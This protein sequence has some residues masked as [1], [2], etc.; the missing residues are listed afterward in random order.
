MRVRI[1]YTE[2]NQASPYPSGVLARESS[3]L[4]FGDPQGDIPIGAPISQGLYNWT[5]IGLEGE[6]PII[7]LIQ[8]LDSGF[9]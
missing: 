6:I 8:G 2:A 1:T 3:T 9:G 7:I 5:T 4:G